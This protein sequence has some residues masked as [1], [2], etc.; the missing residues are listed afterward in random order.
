M[1]YGVRLGLMLFTLVFTPLRVA[2]QDSA[3]SP[4]P[5]PVPASLDETP[6]FNVGASEWMLTGGGAW[7][8]SLF[9]SESGYDYITQRISWGRVLTPP[10]FPGILRGRFQWAF[11]VTPLHAQYHPERAYGWG[12][13]PIVWRWNL[14]PRG[15]YAPYAE[16]AGGALWTSRPV[17]EQTTTAN[18][19]AHAGA[20]VRFFVSPR[21]AFVLAYLFDHI[22][23]GNRL[24]QNP[25][26]NAHSIH[27]GY[28]LL[29]PGK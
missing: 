19:H 16:L 3:T 15:R 4:A 24:Q 6:L 14:E 10:V 17:P 21:N 13:A 23:N 28:T 18:F 1:V 8:V 20:G 25:G 12:I 2:A 29:K 7:S 5:Q 9:H 27:F 11:E 26:V 22:S